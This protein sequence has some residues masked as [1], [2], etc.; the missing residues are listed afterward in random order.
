MIMKKGT[1]DDKQLLHAATYLSRPRAAGLK[2][3]HSDSA[4]AIR[5]EE[6]AER[7][8]R[9]GPHTAI[10]QEV[11]QVTHHANED[12]SNDNDDGTAVNWFLT[13]TSNLWNEERSRWLEIA[14]KSVGSLI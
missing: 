9:R 7:L 14:E 6:P 1:D 11:A 10:E 12:S 5:R 8:R 13:D 2:R 3:R 4:A